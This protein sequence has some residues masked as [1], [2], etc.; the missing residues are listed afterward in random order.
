MEL[1]KRY[2]A[3]IFLAIFLRGNRQCHCCLLLLNFVVKLVKSGRK[4]GRKDLAG[5]ED[6]RAGWAG[7]KAA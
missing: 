6:G 4:R 5:K 7:G 1:E 3:C 2:R